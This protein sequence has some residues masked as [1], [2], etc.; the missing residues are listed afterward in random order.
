MPGKVFLHSLSPT[1]LSP[2]QF[3][4]EIPHPTAMFALLRGLVSNHEVATL[5]LV[6]LGPNGARLLGELLCFGRTAIT[7]IAPTHS[8]EHLCF[9]IL[10]DLPPRGLVF[11]FLSA[12][13]RFPLK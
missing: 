13:L 12:W 11:F 4:L 5:I 6:Q 3:L 2:R 7:G 8:Y 10:L 9:F 1:L